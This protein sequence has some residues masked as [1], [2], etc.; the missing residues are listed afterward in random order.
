[1]TMSDCRSAS[2]RCVSNRSNNCARKSPPGFS[3]PFSRRWL[4]STG[5]ILPAIAICPQ[6]AAA[7]PGETLLMDTRLPL[8]WLVLAGV[9]AIAAIAGVIGLLARMR[10][11]QDAASAQ[12]ADLQSENAKL[13][14]QLQ[15]RAQELMARDKALDEA[16]IRAE[17]QEE[18]HR[19]FLSITSHRMRNPLEALLGTLSLLA[20]GEDEEMCQL[21]EAALGQCRLLG[22]GIEDIQRAGQAMAREQDPAPA[23]E[24]GQRELEILLIENDGHPS[25]RARLEALGHR[26][27]RESNGVDGAEAVLKGKYDL[28][29][30]DIRLPLID[31]V[32]IARKIR[33]DYAKESLLVFG[34]LENPTQADRE[35]YVARGLTGIL[36]VKPSEA[37]L[38]QLLGWVDEKTRRASP[39]G[40]AVR[41]SKVLNLR[42]LERQRDTLGH[43]AFA[44]LVG[45]RLANLPKKITAFTSELT[46]RH[47][48][49]AQHLAQAIAAE[50]DSVG[51]EMVASR[52]RATAARLTIDGEREYCRHQRTEILG[53]MRS[54]IQQ[55]KAWRE[56]NVHTEWALR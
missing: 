28:V 56:K 26:V 33:G 32:E 35:H 47:W 1:M 20:K 29:L 50:A 42:T 21:A 53:L 38:L 24:E 5:W 15:A 25:L 11:I 16:R 7:F 40:K 44:E 46:G 6:V 18:E 51:L 22:N 41:T 31:G 2:G 14:R 49:D 30:V 54:S 12:V 48:L 34:M 43:L 3:R 45:D 4:L 39:S 13:F 10:A 55:L 36:P 9:A 23:P 27:R 17:Q 37:Q 52:L 8:L 19:D